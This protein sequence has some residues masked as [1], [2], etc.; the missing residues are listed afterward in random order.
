[1][2]RPLCGATLVG[3]LALTACGGGSGNGD[4]SDAAGGG[5]SGPEGEFTIAY[6][7]QPPTLDPSATTGTVTRHI[8]RLMYEQLIAFDSNGEVRPVLAESFDHSEDAT[9]VTFQLRDDV[10]FHN[11]EPMEATDV[12][13]SLERWVELADVGQQY[14]AEADIDSPEDGVVT[15]T[16][17]EGMGVMPELLAE[18][19]Q[20]PYIMPAEIA[21]EADPDGATE[22]IG[23]GPYQYGEWATDQHVRLDA[24]ASYTSPAGETDGITGER[25]ANFENIYFNF[26]SDSSTRLTGIQTLE[27]DMAMPLPWDNA[28]MI[29]GTDG[30]YIE[31]GETTFGAVIFNKQQ[32][33]MADI[34]MRR[35]VYAAFEP[36]P[37]LQAAFNNDQFYGTATSLSPESSPWYH[38][39]DHEMAD[40]VHT[41][42]LDAAE[43]YLEEADYAGETLT[44]MTTRDNEEHY[45]QAVIIQ[46][47]LIDAGI[48]VE[49]EVLDWPSVL[50]NQSNPDIWDLTITGFSWRELPA[51]NAFLQ[52]SFAGWTDDDAIAEAIEDFLYAGSEDE[53]VQAAADLQDAYFEYLPVLQTGRFATLAA[54]NDDYEGFVNIPGTGEVYYHV[55]RTQ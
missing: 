27:Y 23:T 20:S 2:R 34:N 18:P 11:G 31:P 53:A 51:T 43:Q 44:F 45:N 49:L 41:Q 14:F 54:L 1:M 8:G 30:V 10:Q 24:F 48:D 19:T 4:D 26:V 13:A 37:V 36:E 46:Q 25:E 29:D 6:G 12:V 15:V 42:D 38:E 32:G 3:L 55:D 16:L 52:P 21:Q 33:P 28:E 50:E 40:M 22:N 17:P 5:G 35:A 39:S 7:S 47:Q 9:T